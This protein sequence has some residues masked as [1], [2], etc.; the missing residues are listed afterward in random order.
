MAQAIAVVVA[1]TGRAFAR[2]AEGNLRALKAGDTLKEGEVVITMSGGSVELAMSDGAPMTVAADQT[3]TLTADVSETTRPAREDAEIIQGTVD[4]VIQALERGADIE[5]LE[6]PAAGLSGGGGGEGNN[7]VRLLRITEGV[8][9]LEFD[10][11]LLSTERLEPE[12]R[13][14][15]AEEE[16]PV[17][18]TVTLSDLIVFEG[19]GTATITATVSSP[20]TGSDL[21]IE[22]SNGAVIVIPVG[23]TTGTSTPFPIQGEDPYIDP[24]TITIEVVDTG[25]SDFGTVTPTGPATV[26]VRD[27]IDSTNTSLTVTLEAAPS[28]TEDGTTLTYVVTLDAPVRP[29]D[30]PVRVSFIDLAGNPQTITI[31]EGTSAFLDVLIPEALFEDVYKEADAMLPV[32]TNVVLTGGSD[33]EALD[34]PVVG[35][36]TLVDTIDTTTVTLGDVTVAEGSG[37]ATITATVSNPVTG[38]ALVI[39]LSNGATVTIPVGQSSAVSTP[40]AVQGDDPYLDAE[41]YA[42]SITGAAGGNYEAL[43]TSDTATVTIDDTTN[44]T[45]VTLGDVAVAEGS[46][47]ATITATVSNPVTGSALVITLSNGAMVTIPVGQSSAVST[48]FA[49]QGDD[50]YLDAES[51]AVSITG[52]AGGNYEALDTSD[53]ATV[54]IDDTTNTITVTL[55]DVAVAEGSGTATITATVSNPVTG[56]ALVITLSN[57]ATVTIPVGESSA[58]STPFAVQ[59]DDPYVDPESYTVSIAGTAGGNYEALDTSD[60]AT[61]TID[62]TEDTTIVM[63]DA[64]SEV[65]EL[66]GTITYTAS[67][68]DAPLGTPLT[69]SLS[70][71]A[72]IVIPVGSLSG[73]TTVPM[74]KADLE[75]ISGDSVTVTITDATGGTY[76]ALDTS[77]D[78]VTRIDRVVEVE[79]DSLALNEADLVGAGGTLTPVTAQGSF[80]I[81]APDGVGSLTIQNLTIGDMQVIVDGVFTPTSATTPLGNT[82]A[83]TAFDPATGTITYSYEL[84][85][86]ETHTQPTNDTEL[87]E[88]FGVVV[89]DGDPVDPNVASSLLTVTITDDRPVVEIQELGSSVSLDE[90]NAFTGG[91]PGSFPI[92]ATSADPV[93]SFTSDFGADGAAA[94]N[95]TTYGLSI[96]GDGATLLKTAV[97]DQAITLVQTSATTITGQYGAGLT[98]FTVSIGADGKLTVTQSVALEHTTD[99]GT[100]ADHNDALTLNGLINASVT[101]TDADGDTATDSIGVGGAISFYDDG[102]AVDVTAVASSV[103]LDETNAFTG[104]TPGSFPI[105]ATSADPVLSFTSDFGADGAAASNA[106][107]YGLSIVGDGATLLKT[108]VGDQ[109]ITL[110]QTSATTI[111]G[112]YGAGLTAFTV[113]IGAD[114]KL[115]VTQSVALEHTTDGGTAADHNDALT[116]NGL[117]NASVTVTDADGDTATDSI[118][119]GGAISFYDDGPAVDVTAV[120]SSVRLDETNAFTGGT[121]GSF[122]ITATSA[123][124]V[125]S[126][127]SD[128]GAD[129]AAASGATTYGLSIVGDGATLL[130]TAV[131]DQAITLVQTSATT[132]TGQYGAGLTAFTVSIG[133]DGKLTVTQSVALEH[134]TDGGTATDHNDALTLNGLINASVTV[135]D[136]DGDT[137]TDS[138]GVGGAISFYDDGPA[139]DV[140]AV[141][142]SVSLDE[143]N[144]FTGGTPGSFPITATS[145][146]PVLSFTSDFGADGAAASNATTYGLSIVGDG[147]TLL[148]TAVGDQAITLVQTSAT[149]ITG[150]YGAGLTAFTVSIGADGKLTVTQSVALEHT[151]DGGTAADHNDALT[152]NGLINASVTV[153]DADG[154]TA[155]D[156]IGVGGA[157]SFY[158]DGPAVDVTAV[159]SSVRLDETNAFTGGTPGSFPIT[160]TSADPVLSFTSDFGADGA[161]A[162]NA[163][164]YGLSIVGDGA[165]L[166]KTAV[167]DQAIT[168]VQTSA[169]TITGQ[170]GAGLTAFTVSIG[171]DGKLTVT[172]SVAL[173]HTTDGGTAADH[174]DALTLNGLINASVTVTDADGDTATDSIGVGGAISFYDDGPAVDVTA[175]ASSVRLD[176]TNAFTGGTPGSFPITATSADPVLSFTSDFGADGAAASG[177]TTYGLSIVGDGA[178]LLKTAVGDQAI[179][180]VQTSATTITGQYGAGLTAFTV[181]IGADGKLTVTQSVALE[182]TTDG[183]TATDHNDALTLNGLINASVTV[184]DA[185]GDTATDSIGVGGAISFYDDGPAVDVTA[186]ASSVSL[187]ETN[188]FTG[189]TP[190]SFPITATSADPVLSFTSDFGADGAAAS[191]ATTYG[192]SIVGDGATLLKTAVGDQAITLVQTSATTI[193]GQYGAGLT[194]FTV[195][196]GADGKLT[197]TQS[198]A[199]EHT[200]DGGTAAD[201][202]DALT[203]N[204]LIN[205]S[206]TVTDADG[207]T[208]TD[209]IGVG[210]AI[211]FYDDGPA[212]D[213]TA[214]ASSVR[215]DE[216]NAFTGGTPGSFPITAT[217]ADPVLSFTSDFGADGAAASGATTYGLSI[218][219]DG[220]TLLKTA[221][222]DQAIT[223]VQTSATTITGQYG[224]GLT[225]FTVSIGADGK[226]TVTQSVALEHT[227][228]GGTAADHNDALTLNGLINASVTVTDADGDTATDSIG[229]GGAI[230]FYD[231]GPRVISPDAAVLSDAVGQSQWFGLDRDDSVTDNYGA[232]GGTVRFSSDLSSYPALTSGLQP[233]SYSLSPDGLVLTAST[234][235]GTVFTVTLDPGNAQYQ[236]N[237]IGTVDGGV[238]TIDFNQPGLYNFTGGNAA[239]AGFN[240]LANDDS[241]DLLITPMIK[242]GEVYA[243]GSTVNTNATSGGVGAGGSVGT[244][245]AIRID[246]VTDLTGDPVSGKPYVAGDPTHDFEGH[247]TTNGASALFLGISGSNPTSKVRIRAYD[248]NDGD[249]VVGDGVQ[250]S[251]TAVGVTY[252]GQSLLVSVASIGTAAT[253]YTIGGKTFTVQFIDVDPTDATKYEVT[254]DGVAGGSKDGT[255]I[256]TYTA[257]GYSS[258]EYYHDGGQP[259][260][261]G[262]FG[263]TTINEGTPVSFGLPIEVVDNDGD[264]ASTQ[265]NVTLMPEGL[266]TADYSS[267]TTGVDEEATATSPNIIGSSHDD[268]LT[269]DEADNVLYGGAGGDVLAGEGGNDYL[270]G[271]DGD[272]ELTGGLGNDIL[273]GGVGADTFKWSLADVGAGAVPTDTIKDFDTAAYGDGGDRLDLGDLLEGLSATNESL[274]NYLD[275]SYDSATNSTTIS[276]HSGGSGTPVDQVVVLENV[277]LTNGGALTSDLAIISDLMTKG[278][279]ITD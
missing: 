106:T 63:L 227:T 6:E 256:A 255:Q 177:A 148:K 30:D 61:V 150:Q 22:L 249:N 41:S 200:T 25:G 159:A 272:D 216:T 35:S 185:D 156:S 244:G 152:L 109:A 65:P 168:L 128:F 60:T 44:T 49:V 9:P 155:T 247:Y 175:V 108:A 211:S 250:D 143:T 197:V 243:S 20:V 96:V 94:S 76:E 235:A 99:G 56:S 265:I 157:I 100:A 245:E 17:N 171:A 38:N 196:I 18:A 162:S 71:G 120:A 145:A 201:H 47:T 151:T 251:I 43:D 3:V 163:T 70:N 112:Q 204:G 263:A 223:L 138:I 240:T 92:T 113:S 103:S 55:G 26:E 188:A 267:S 191:N 228:D 115:T 58:A 29:G 187:D 95:A 66:G 268:S 236:V 8:T 114:G 12:E 217:S 278:K 68:A 257:T 190:G 89:T 206:V 82:L 230:S 181:S 192:L 178:T 195:S 5:D 104:G 241:N 131:G 238:T 125:L 213:V 259:F 105:T 130:K 146:D 45:T 7:F 140:T 102:P 91:T 154:D 124:P 14:L 85:A 165:T 186:V 209:S 34:P 59:G 179:T 74:T 266:P 23:S 21:V 273:D 97:G 141:A 42:V 232:D 253:S 84:N 262:D 167:G 121:P 132:I 19:S 73:S 126:F 79:G 214:V 252:N 198:V 161:A 122:P 176:E 277:D 225:A 46:G 133:A 183:G 1:V 118:G 158:D 37:T 134:T 69:I 242:T 93:L 254:I 226:L 169:T 2:D 67:V 194:A 10:Y 229:V 39:T 184:T 107:T 219:G 86:A 173:E 98:A 129:G 62:D 270:I 237:M 111:T 189:G 13:G 83:V 90:T 215:L 233:I 231:D 246:F 261:V 88:Q 77:D 279:L 275:F 136:A 144:A 199:L 224:A 264:F 205:A 153:T 193:T 81:T 271:G 202:N 51:Y 137:A 234:S 32:A 80:V 27:T 33:F 222:G 87:V 36:V 260:S 101:V 52:A 164:T 4:Q 123:D 57:G 31:T 11:R 119:V 50:P 135:T 258:L 16:E 276:V 203:L 127:T 147:A 166:L 48:P 142:S 139:V 53:T 172:Q 274:D 221:V 180:L 160:A 116:L 248:D 40:F 207:D 182:H 54:T 212:V 24:E 78:A 28:L 269:G 208:A 64:S 110:V 174:N 239:W 218:V 72:E 220:A 15:P 149:T 210:G 117:I 170:Y 75:A